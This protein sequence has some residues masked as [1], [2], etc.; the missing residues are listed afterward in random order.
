MSD[1]CHWLAK[2]N[3]DENNNPTYHVSLTFV[4]YDGI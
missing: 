2:I 4:A 1:I 3:I